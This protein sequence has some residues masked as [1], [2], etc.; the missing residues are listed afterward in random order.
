VQVKSRDWP[1][2]AEMER[3]RSFPAPANCRKILHRW[4]DRQRIPDVR[5]LAS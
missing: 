1:G 4:R 2:L 5:E 3:L